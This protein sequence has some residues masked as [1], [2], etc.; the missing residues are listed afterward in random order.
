[1]INVVCVAGM[2]NETE[3]AVALNNT[4]FHNVPVYLKQ[5]IPMMVVYTVAYSAVFFLGIML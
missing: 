1:M 5:S 2:D 3:E 4:V